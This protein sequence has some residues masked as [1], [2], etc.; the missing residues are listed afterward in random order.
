MF[1]L[2]TASACGLILIYTCQ[3]KLRYNILIFNCQVILAHYILISINMTEYID[4]TH[5]VQLNF[6]CCTPFISICN[7]IVSNDDIFLIHFAR[8]HMTH[9]SLDFI[10]TSIIII[11]VSI[12]AVL[13]Q[14]Y[15]FPLAYVFTDA[16]SQPRG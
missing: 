15:C 1:L 6:L 3:L 16:C 10:S 8:L 11:L 7:A 5:F 14:I 13:L 12:N 2:A 9:A 4:N